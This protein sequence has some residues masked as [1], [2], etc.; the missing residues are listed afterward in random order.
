MSEPAVP[1]RPAPMPGAGGK[2]PSRG[3]VTLTHV[4]SDLGEDLWKDLRA[5]D[6]RKIVL[7]V[8]AGLTKSSSRLAEQVAEAT[9]ARVVIATRACFGACDPPSPREAPGAEA[10]VALGHSP[11]PNMRV[12]LPTYFVEMRTSEGDVRRLASVVQ[13][14]GLPRRLGL[15]ASIQHMDLIPSFIAAMA[16][17]GYSVKVGSGDRR[18]TYPGQALGCNYTTAEAIE[19]EIDGVLFLGTGLFHPLGLA[20]AMERPVWAL[21]PMQAELSPPLDRD[22]MVR[23][24]LLTVAK[25]MDARR[26]GVL[27]SSFAG[28]DRSGMAA[29]L[30]E[31]AREKGRSAEVLVFD[32]LDPRDLMG[33]DYDAYVCTACPRIALDDGASYERPML[34]PPEFLS[35]LGER[36]LTP[37]RFDTFH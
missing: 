23:K 32:R 12:D 21:D 15:V 36:P 17:R 3:R 22:A 5:A 2:G 14:A 28:Q 29:S 30:A 11:I 27:V 26:W 34:T 4:Y 24:R 35:A 16:E 7:Q 37:Y 9:G 33:R 25:A 10:L 19:E 8:P 18:L 1:D 13:E 6:Y 20:L 31:K